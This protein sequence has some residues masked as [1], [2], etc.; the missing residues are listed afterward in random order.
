MSISAG[1][2]VLPRQRHDGLE[3]VARDDE[4]GGVRVHEGELLQ[5]LLDRL[6][7]LALQVQPLEGR[8]EALVLLALGVGRKAELLLDGLHLLLEKELALALGDLLV[9]LLLDLLLDP[10]QLLLLV[11]EDEGL[12]HALLHVEGLEHLLLLGAL[13]VEDAGHEVG[14]LARVVD[15]HHAHPHLLG[16]QGVVLRHLA[17]LGD[18]RPGERLDLDACRGS[19]PPGT[20]RRP[21]EARSRTGTS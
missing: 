16:E 11:D 3:V 8:L 20:R 5:L 21:R 12:L 4:L 6:P 10:Q 14:D 7:G 17:H 15:V 18:Q 9:D 1:H 2:R 13:D 19:R